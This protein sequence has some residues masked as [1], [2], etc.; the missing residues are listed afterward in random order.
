MHRDH[1]PEQHSAPRAEPM[2][3]PYR[4]QLGVLT[5]CPRHPWAGPN[6]SIIDG[7]VP[8]CW[9]GHFLDEDTARELVAA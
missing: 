2:R 4:T 6:V 5:T 3:G 8:V 7:A 1:R 9:E